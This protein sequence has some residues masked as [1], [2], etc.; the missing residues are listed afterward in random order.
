MIRVPLLPA[1]TLAAGMVLFA[2]TSFAQESP[3][4]PIGL[5]LTTDFPELTERI[6]DAV[7]IPLTLTDAGMPPARVEFAVAGLPDGWSWEIDGAGKP[8][9]AA[10]VGPD[11][12]RS[13]DLKLT[14]PKT[15]KPGSY[16]FTVS[17]KTDAGQTLTLP[18]KM[19]LAEA[20]PAEVKVEPKLPA[21]VGTPRSNFDFDLTIT[22][23]S[24]EDATFNLLAQTPPG[25]EATFKEQYG[26]QELTSLPIKAG[27]NKAVKLSVT[28]PKTVNA[29]QYPVAVAAANGDIQGQ[30]QLALDITG[31]PTVSLTGPDGR[32]SGKAEAGQEATFNFTV[33]NSGT[34]PAKAVKLSASAPS[35]WTVAFDPATIDALAPEQNQQVVA[36]VTPSDKAI[37]G[38]YMVTMR[39][40]GDGTSDSAD[41]R[42]S[43]TTSTLW[44]IGGLGVIAA[45]VVVLGFSV[46]RYG[47]R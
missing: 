35:G 44:G 7:R 37:A 10:M 25:F 26:S 21:L 22:N 15:A 46:T 14:E 1:A 27:E 3:T 9:M 40:S 38:D 12:S 8:V 20:E 19:T 31:Q 34:A 39:A 45:A 17:A 23:S 29:G 42:V 43:V 11:D 6:G 18:V 41:F 32:L 5:W 47:R 2:Q 13:L 30:A 36:H 4:K 33:S 16:A 24:A 28:P